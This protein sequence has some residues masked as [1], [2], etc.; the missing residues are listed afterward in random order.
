MTIDTT[1]DPVTDVRPVLLDG[2]WVATEGPSFRTRDPH[3][4]EELHMFPVSSWTD[5][6]RALAAGARAYRDLQKAGPER[7]AAF[8]EALAD[9][10]E[11]DADRLCA[12]A[13]R[14]TALPEQGRLR[15]VELPRTT[16]QLRQGAAAARDRSWTAPI[17][18][19][20]RGLGS[21]LAPIPGVVVVFGPNN[22]PFA[23]N[24]V[25]GGDAVAALASGHPVL[26]KGNPGHPETTRLLAGHAR[27]AAEDAGLPV[28]VVQLVYSC[29]HADGNRLVADPRVAATAF[30]G[31][32]GAGLA[33]KAAADAAGKPIYLEMSSVNPIV[34]L[35]DAWAHRGSALADEVGISA[36]QA[37][38]Q[39]CTSPGLVLA[40]GE[41]TFQGLRDALRTRFAEQPAATLLGVP[42]HLDA[43]HT[44]LES[45]GAVVVLRGN[46]GAG[47]C[48]RP[49]TL[50][51]ADA[52][53]FVAEAVALGEEAF[54]NSTLLVACRDTADVVAC[55]A[56]LGGQ[57]TGTVYLEETESDL[58]AYAVL[59]PLL[60]ERVGRLLNNKV[61]TGVA[62]DPAM[63]HGG[64]FPAGG[65]P[66]WTA[67][68]IPA[69]LRRFAML[70]SYDN[71]PDSRLPPELQGANPLGLQRCVDGRWT[72]ESVTW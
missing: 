31:S 61:P 1:A 41:R 51:T 68:G 67:V 22:F 40:V 16:G 25:T 52:E 58:A 46:P 14:E 7:M 21:R 49:N 2:E 19:P 15:E 59:E 48:S 5:L 72:T 13:A 32:K 29:S 60:R 39:F 34:V 11:A 47:V 24:S 63:N 4:G 35:P 42:T 18:S 50:F 17:L 69:S 37:G 27:A 9:R 28:A 12:T 64:P 33:L 57:L 56:A 20:E 45:A 23:F 66:G 10:L 65:H 36:L 71:V 43:A 30:T 62:V 70:Q 8:L 44:R 54:G 6:D 53:Q 38:G 55:V 3:S 26:A